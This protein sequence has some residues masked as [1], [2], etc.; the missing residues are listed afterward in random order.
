M[1]N[2]CPIFTFEGPEGNHNIELDVGVL[3]DVLQ[4]P[5]DLHHLFR[6]KGLEEFT[7]RILFP[8]KLFRRG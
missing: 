7:K 5:R 4:N 1:P 2:V 8:E 3:R 6:T